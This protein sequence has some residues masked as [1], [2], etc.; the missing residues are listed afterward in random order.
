MT[1]PA[2]SPIDDTSSQALNEPKRGR[3]AQFDSEHVLG[4]IADLFWER[5]YDGVSVSD[6]T[7][8]TGLSKSSLYNS[9]GGKDALFTAALERYD[10]QNVQAGADWLALDDGS[11]PIEKLDQ[12]FRGPEDDVYGQNDARG[13]FLCNTSADGQTGG[14]TGRAPDVDVLV[15]VGFAKLESGLTTLLTRSAPNA[16]EDRVRDAARLALTTYTGLRIR[17]R[18]KPTRAEFKSVRTAMLAAVQALL[19]TD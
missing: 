16:P 4:E 5:G 18:T 17:S 8:A 14:T 11:D 3:P 1:R 2:T 10:T 7:A 13:C 19:Q 6:I 12:L 15:G 9:F